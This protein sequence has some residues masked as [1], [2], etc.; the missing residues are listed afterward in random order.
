MAENSAKVAYM[1]RILAI[2][3]IIVGCLLFCLGLGDRYLGKFC[4]GTLTCLK[5]RKRAD[6]DIIEGSKVIMLIHKPALHVLHFVEANIVFK[7]VS[8]LIVP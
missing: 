7:F 4:L 2:V 3:D 8:H 6:V 5:N 1:A